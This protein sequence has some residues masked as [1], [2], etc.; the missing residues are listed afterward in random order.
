MNNKVNQIYKS[1]HSFYEYYLDSKKFN[2]LSKY[3][4]LVEFFNDLNKF[5]K[6]E[7]IREKTEKNKKCVYYIF[8]II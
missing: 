4:F 3:S 7:T 5:K 6:L 8:K 1:K 2:N